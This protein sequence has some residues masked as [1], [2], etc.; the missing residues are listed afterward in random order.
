M[1][2]NL[3]ALDDY[4]VHINEALTLWVYSKKGLEIWGSKKEPNHG[5]LVYEKQIQAESI[6][7]LNIRHWQQVEKSSTKPVK[8]GS[9]LDKRA[10]ILDLFDISKKVG[11]AGEIDKFHEFAGGKLKWDEMRKQ[12]EENIKLIAEVGDENFRKFGLVTSII[13]GLFAASNIA[14][15]ITLPLFSYIGVWNYF[16]WIPKDLQSTTTVIITMI[17]ISILISYYWKIHLR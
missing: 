1:E 8:S 14:L 4:S 3:R 16:S 2:P 12:A 11:Y 10:E 15:Q 6:N 13:F 7:Y 9:I 17:A 5:E